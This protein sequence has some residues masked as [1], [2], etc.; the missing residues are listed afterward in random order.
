MRARE[1]RRGVM[2]ATGP[3]VRFYIKKIECTRISACSSLAGNPATPGATPAGATLHAMGGRQRNSS[4]LFGG[5]GSADGREVLQRDNCRGMDEKTTDRRRPSGSSQRQ[6]DGYI[7][8]RLRAGSGGEREAEGGEQQ[9]MGG[10]EGTER[11]GAGSRRLGSLTLSAR[12]RSTAVALARPLPR[13]KHGRQ[14]AQ[15][16]AL[17]ADAPGIFSALHVAGMLPLPSSCLCHHLDEGA[18]SPR[19]D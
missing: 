18:V 1:E 14:N 15:T 16:S 6:L 9:R 11:D 17:P 13:S 8:C 10:K 7:V 4:G 12:V 19:L 2:A 3:S 5:G